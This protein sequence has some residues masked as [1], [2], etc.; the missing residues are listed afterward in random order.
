MNF[1]TF[2]IEEWYLEKSYF[3]N[4]SEKYAEYDKYLGNILDILDEQKY[5]ATFFCLGGM[6]TD[7]PNVIQSIASR[8]HEI[9]CHSFKHVWLNQMAEKEVFEDTRTSIDAIEQ[10]IGRKVLSYR[11]PAFSIGKGNKWAFE[12]LAQNG[13]RRDASIF[14]AERDFGGFE[15]FG[16]NIPTMVYCNRVMLKEFPICTTKI[17]GK[18]VA[19]SGGGYFR[20]FPMKFIK[21]EMAKSEYNMTYFHIADLVPETAGIMSKQ[22][23]E[24]YFKVPGTLKNRLLRHL[25]TNV[26]K[27]GSMTKLSKL[28][29][30]DIFISLEQADS[31][32]DWNNQPS[33][34]I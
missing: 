6:A 13:I 8:G 18:E 14:P 7:F 16:K 15:G 10:C 4:H 26:G 31:M 11:A 3:G 5:K 17:F 32:I 21:S 9:G 29:K 20:F 22:D 34:V 27:K 33:V 30:D 19:Y 24:K 1:F 25:K 23:F 28:L 2:D 12:V